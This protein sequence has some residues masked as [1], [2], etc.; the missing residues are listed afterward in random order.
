MEETTEVRINR[1]MLTSNLRT[2]QKHVDILCALLTAMRAQYNDEG[3][4]SDRLMDHAGVMMSQVWN[5]L[6]SMAEVMKSDDVPF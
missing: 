6:A 2:A 4:M 1:T 3:V 5:S